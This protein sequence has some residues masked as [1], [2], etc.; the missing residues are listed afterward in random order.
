MK[1]RTTLI[2]LVVAIVFGLAAY[3]VLNRPSSPPG[4]DGDAAAGGT[5]PAGSLALPGFDPSTLRALTVATPDGRTQRVERAADP[6]EWSLVVAGADGGQGGSI[7]WPL[8]PTRMRSILTLMSTLRAET[9]ADANATLGASPTV[10]TLELDGG[11]THTLRLAE[12]TLGGSGLI[13]Y[14]TPDA[15]HRAIVTDGFINVFRNPGPTA[16]RNTQALPGVGPDASRIRL[17]NA[18][19]AITLVRSAGRWNLTEP[20]SA[21]ADPAKVTQVIGALER[22]TITDF[23]DGR[24]TDDAITR[25]DA[26]TARIRVETDE[27]TASPDPAAPPTVAT[28]VITLDVGGPAD[29]SG[30]NLFVAVGSGSETGRR[31]VAVDATGLSAALTTNPADYIAPAAARTIPADV[32]VLSLSTDPAIVAD[33]SAAG[34][35]VRRGERR[36]KRS[37]GA[38]ADVLEDGRESQLADGDSNAVNEVLT[39]LNTRKPQRLAVAPPDG[40][41]PAGAIVLG[42]PAG[43]PLELFEIGALPAAAIALRSGDVYRVYPS[44]ASPRLLR[45]WLRGAGVHVGPPAVPDPVK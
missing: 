15:T 41:T 19:A 35:P 12:R 36:F 32:G 8:L 42:T 25:L 11:A 44:D 24:S 1:T 22:L 33:A 6:A 20:V 39:F 43:E 10:V 18:D 13:E 28:R 26:P 30:R 31:I 34:G 21:P 23:L 2:W 4:A 27:R 14:Q 40:Y 37:L 5:I 29:A 45:D 17:A 9:T 38:W 16:W 7:T 3:L